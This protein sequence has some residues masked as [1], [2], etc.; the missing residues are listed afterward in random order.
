MVGGGG[1]HIVGFSVAHSFVPQ[2]CHAE[3]RRRA[4]ENVQEARAERYPRE[5]R[6]IRGCFSLL[7][8]CYCFVR[9]VVVIG[10]DEE[11]GEQT[12]F[13]AQS[14]HDYVRFGSVKILKCV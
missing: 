7:A 8:I 10:L 6:D 3:K 2:L 11:D 14:T 1:F 12:R 5:S 9:F 13:P 4:A